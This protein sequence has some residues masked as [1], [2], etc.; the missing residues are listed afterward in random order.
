M[1][2]R[3]I[4][5]YS[6]MSDV[7]LINAFRNSAELSMQEFDMIRTVMCGRYMHMVNM[8]KGSEEIL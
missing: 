6:D 8:R 4:D 2:T 1:E 7:D 5:S 3:K